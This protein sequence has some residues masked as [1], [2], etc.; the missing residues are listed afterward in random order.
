MTPPGLFFPWF[1]REKRNFLKLEWQSWYWILYTGAGAVGN[2]SKIYT[3]FGSY[4][5]DVGVGFSPPSA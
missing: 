2:D 1:L 4:I 5:P 3:D